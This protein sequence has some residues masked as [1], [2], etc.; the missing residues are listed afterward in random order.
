MR[1]MIGA[2]LGAGAFYYLNHAE[3]LYVDAL[4]VPVAFITLGVVL[5]KK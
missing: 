5:L 3:W 1:K 2:L 4:I